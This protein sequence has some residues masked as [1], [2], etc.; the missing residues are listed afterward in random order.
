[1]LVPATL[2]I[3]SPF[4]TR[5]WSISTLQFKEIP[6]SF[7]YVANFISLPDTCIPQSSADIALLFYPTFNWRCFIHYRI[8]YKTYMKL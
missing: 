2:L 6:T 4:P 8:I 1:M 7:L 3:I 5:G